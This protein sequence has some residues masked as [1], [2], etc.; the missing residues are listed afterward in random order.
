MKINFLSSSY[1][2]MNAEHYSDAV[3]QKLVD[4]FRFKGYEVN[5]V[6]MPSGE[7]DVSLKK[8][9]LFQ[10]VLGLQTALKVNISTT[11]PHV[12]VKMGIGIF[13]QQAIPTVLTVAVWWPIAVCQIAGLVKQYKMDQEVFSTLVDAFNLVAGRTVSYRKID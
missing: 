7:W 2:F 5:S 8:G 11:S 6:K 10:A 4:E 9:N 12:L 13:G 1:L 3:V